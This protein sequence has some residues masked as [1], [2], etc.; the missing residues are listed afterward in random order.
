M[1][2]SP[3]PG[4]GYLLF[5]TGGGGKYYGAILT[6]LMA[7]DAAKLAVLD[8]R[9][10]TAAFGSNTD[11][12]QGLPLS[13]VTAPG[14]PR[15]L[16]VSITGRDVSLAWRN[17]GDATSFVLDIGLAPGRTDFS[18]YRDGSTT[19]AF[20]GVASG[21]FYVRVRGANAIGGGRPSADTVVTVP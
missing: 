20:T 5:N 4:R 15:D 19:A 18:V 10:V 3:H 8:S 16:T 9:D 1:R 13:L 12:C 14:A 11:N 2:V 17:V 6:S 21:R 7:F